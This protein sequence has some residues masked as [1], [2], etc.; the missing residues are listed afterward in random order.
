MATDDRSYPSVWARPRRKERS[1]LTREQIVAQALELLD[2]EGI[3]ALSMRKLAARLDAGATSL[4]WHVANRDEL[5]ELL[6]DEIYGELDLPDADVEIGPDDWRDITRRFAQ[7]V[8]VIARR[9][10]W[11]VSVIDHLAAAHLGPNQSRAAER[12]L[13]AFEAAGFELGEAEQAFKVMAAYV[14]GISVTEAAWHNWL[15]RHGQTQEDW[16]ATDL[17][18]AE[19]TSGDHERLRAVVDS[20]QGV[21]PQTSMDRDFEY[22]LER[23][24]DGLQARLD[25]PT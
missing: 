1:T 19:E 14:N 10:P 24:F 7:S 2:A 9:H 4:Y 18:V 22:G 6:I 25:H 11:M 15:A 12:M 5:I 23:I 3:E 20:Y 17:Q 21:D 13:A 8:R 16:L